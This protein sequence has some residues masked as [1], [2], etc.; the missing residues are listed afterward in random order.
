MQ[1]PEASEM[2]AGLGM[3]LLQGKDLREG[4]ALGF[5]GAN[6]ALTKA[7][8]RKIQ[9]RK[10]SLEELKA[11]KPQIQ[12]SGVPGYAIAIYP[13]GRVEQIVNDEAVKAYQANEDRKD[14]RQD[15]RQQASDERFD[16]RQAAS[17]A[18]FQQQMEAQESRFLRNLNLQREKLQQK[19]LSAGEFKEL[20]EAEDSVAASQDLEQSIR[21][22]LE[23][24][25]KALGGVGASARRFAGRNAPGFLSPVTGG[26]VPNRETVEATTEFENTITQNA[27]RSL[28]AVFGGNPTEGERKILLDVQG[29]IKMSPGERKKILENALE[30]ARTKAQRSRVRAEQIQSGQFSTRKAVPGESRTSTGIKFTIEGN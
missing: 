24:N 23:L 9:A 11:N 4:L 1:N 18:R 8:E 27:L 7:Q 2:I 22:A 3:G 17:D 21:R 15:K 26:L 29:S 20:M 14:E 12:Q 10:L 19:P 5:Q 28:R 25:D 30:Y 13:D 16:K 6:T